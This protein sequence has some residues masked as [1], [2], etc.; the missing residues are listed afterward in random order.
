M[1]KTLESLVEKDVDGYVILRTEFIATLYFRDGHT[2]AKR[3]EIIECFRE[4][5]NVCGERLRWRASEGEQFAPVLA[6]TSRDIL[7]YLL[8][9]MPEQSDEAWAFF[10]H[11]GEKPED[12]SEFKIFGFGQPNYAEADSLSFLTITLPRTWA[13]EKRNLI[14]KLILSWSNRLQPL[15]GYAGIGIVEAAADGLAANNEHRVYA[16]AMRHAG[17]EVDYPMDHCLNV[18]KKIKGGSW[19][20]VLSQFFIDQLDGVAS[21]KK[22]LGEPFRV[23]EY[24]G[25]GIIIAGAGPEIGDSN[26]RVDTP[27][28][29]TLAR[30]LKPIRITSHSSIGRSMEDWFSADKFEAWLQRFDELHGSRRW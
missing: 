20:T 16:I 12:A 3:S 1:L 4:F 26:R 8:S 5:N 25:G 22:N 6:S 28:Y 21:I 24:S 23:V 30:V 13:L 19:I 14:F 7:S 2:L 11:G 18:A 9:P 29:R 15:H 17:L 27:C 10:W